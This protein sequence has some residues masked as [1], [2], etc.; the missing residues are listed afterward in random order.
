MKKHYDLVKNL[1]TQNYS[2]P[3]YIYSNNVPFVNEGF[4]G[5][6]SAFRLLG[7]E[8]IIPFKHFRCPQP[9]VF[10]NNI[11]ILKINN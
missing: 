4:R 8:V 7:F 3:L 5:R 6:S 2:K 1:Q 10:N 11:Q 9:I